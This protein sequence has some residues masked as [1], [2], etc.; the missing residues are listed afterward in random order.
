MY[1]ST[2][3]LPSAFSL[4]LNRMIAEPATPD[5]A[6]IALRSKPPF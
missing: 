6:P 4:S 3:G 2:S 1:L 5:R